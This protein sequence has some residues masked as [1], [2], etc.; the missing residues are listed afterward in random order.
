ML[1][2]VFVISYLNPWMKNIIKNKSNIGYICPYHV[3]VQ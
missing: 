1:I 2:S 3:G